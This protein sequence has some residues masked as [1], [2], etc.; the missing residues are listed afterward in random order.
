LFPRAKKNTK[1]KKRYCL[2][3]LALRD[4]HS[5][6]PINR[7]THSKLLNLRFSRQKIGLLKLQLLLVVKHPT[8]HSPYAQGSRA[9]SRHRQIAIPIHPL[10]HRNRATRLQ[11]P[12]LLAH[13]R[14]SSA[15]STPPTTPSSKLNRTP[16]ASNISAS[17]SPQTANQSTTSAPQCQSTS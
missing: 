13:R 10:H 15:E 5:Q 6:Y 17:P 1:T 12:L 3:A 14:L 16:S 11:I 2:A 9:L 7:S 8:S 4:P